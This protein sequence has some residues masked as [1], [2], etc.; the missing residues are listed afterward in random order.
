M[1]WQG[2]SANLKEVVKLSREEAR[3]RA[4][5]KG[6]SPYDALLDIFEPDMTSA[7]LDV[8][9]ADMKSWLPDL[10]ANV[11]DKQ[12]RPDIRSASGPLPDGNAA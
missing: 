6:C 12:A 3:L 4:E 7:R 5:A 9:F 2:F 10:L 11:V 8:L 1:T